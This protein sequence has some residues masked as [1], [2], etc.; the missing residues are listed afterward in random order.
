MPSVEGD[1]VVDFP[2]RP[3]PWR[4]VLL[5]CGMVLATA[6]AWLPLVA[7][8]GPRDDAQLIANATTD[9]TQQSPK[10]A[11]LPGGKLV[12]VWAGQGADDDSGIF[13]R[14]RD[15]QTGFG[16]E[17]RVNESADGDQVEPAVAADNAGN[18]LVA[19]TGPSQAV[20][21][22]GAAIPDRGTD[23]FSRMFDATGTPL[24]GEQ[25]LNQSIPGDQSQPAVAALTTRRFAV[26][27][28]GAGQAS[29]AVPNTTVSDDQ[30]IWL[31]TTGDTT[32]GYELLANQSH[33]Q[34]A[35]QHPAAAYDG[36]DLLVAW[37][38]AGPGDDEG[39]FAALSTGALVFPAAFRLNV[40]TDGHQGD[41][42]VAAKSGGFLVAWAGQSLADSAGI[43]LTQVAD[44]QT[45]TGAEIPVNNLTDGD[46]GHPAVAV[47]GSFV[48]IAWDGA[49]G[50]DDSGVQARRWNFSVSLQ[51]AAD[52]FA[53]NTTTTGVEQ[54][55][56]LAANADGDYTVAFEGPG[57][58]VDIFVRHYA[59]ND[60]PVVVD[61]F[62]TTNED[63]PATGNVLANDS[64]P[65][66]DTITVTQVTGS[67]S[68]PDNG[69]VTLNG[70]GTFTYTP[71]SNYHGSDHFSYRA[72]DG[73]ADSVRV[74][75]VTITIISVND[76]GPTANPDG[77]FAATER[78]TLTVT[79]P[80]RGVL[81]NDTDPDND[82]LTARLR[83]NPTSG[84]VSLS[85]DGTF[86]YTGGDHFCG[87]DYFSYVAF[88]GYI[89]SAP[90]RATIHV[91]CVHSPAEARDDQ[92]ST[93]EDAELSVPATGVLQNDFHEQDDP[94]VAQ[95]RDPPAHGTVTLNEDG[96]FDYRPDSNFNGT[97]T[98]T[99]EA[100]ETNPPAPPSSS[101]SPSPL[102]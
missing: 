48:G 3:R 79:D 73:T 59:F 38:G 92:Y 53:V 101:N 60:P 100:V 14:I 82:V 12:V 27:F 9:G 19:W 8:G 54:H 25:R 75:N 11:S 91:N 95:L 88:D 84:A 64:D 63:T 4:P 51:P 10:L 20:D 30:G 65:D 37:D 56:A 71:F 32:D 85:P 15:P 16:P 78:V 33:T 21:A 6:A 72:S 89:E 43:L 28:A 98:F 62:Y 77:P 1:I 49:G 22:Q 26:V 39:V 42:A 47:S 24:R 58:D 94:I 31:G 57:T 44:G 2:R 23:V 7:N 50:V 29:P 99:Y 17:F 76:G 93:V 66:G 55:P 74:A 87:D 36:T 81:A 96:S 52:Q 67:D 46:Q 80:A 5:G 45:Q 41:P 69:S 97:D 86:S 34:G 70:N 35:Q 18:F 102:A 61:D 83:S 90:A 40:T 68:G 13:A